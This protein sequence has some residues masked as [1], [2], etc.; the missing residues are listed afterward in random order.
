M[1]KRDMTGI[2]LMTVVRRRGNKYDNIYLF[3]TWAAKDK[4]FKTIQ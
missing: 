2:T 4:T 3:A 1:H